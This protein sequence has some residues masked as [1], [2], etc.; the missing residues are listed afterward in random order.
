MINKLIGII[1][2]ISL[3]SCHTV[4][5]QKNAQR[6]TKKSLVLGSMGNQSGNSLS[7]DFQSLAI[8]EFDEG[9][10]VDVQFLSFSEQTY[11]AYANA[12]VRQG[13]EIG[14]KLN[15]SLQPHARF[16]LLQISDRE[17]VIQQLHKIENESILH[18]LQQNPK[19]K[20][21]TSVSLYMSGEQ[22]DELQKADQI[23]LKTDSYKNNILELYSDGKRYKKISFKDTTLFAYQLSGFCWGK[24]NKKQW[25][26]SA[27]INENKS[28]I[29]GQTKLYRK[30]A[31]KPKNLFDY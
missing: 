5:V 17:K 11:K 7:R 25:V 3:T 23:F 2:I 19:A 29:R 20:M 26:L 8:P 6:T 24:N 13:K 18:W 1:L 27:L 9:I 15:D 10:S 16:V 12:V 14:F 31:K 30:N 28:C 4:W 22:I 21:I